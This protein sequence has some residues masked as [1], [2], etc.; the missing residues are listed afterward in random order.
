MHWSALVVLLL[1]EI[2]CK[3]CFSQSGLGHQNAHVT[4]ETKL[5]MF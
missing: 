4:R 2:T 5:N 3:T 1:I